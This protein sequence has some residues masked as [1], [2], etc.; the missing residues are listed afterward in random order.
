MTHTRAK[1]Q[2][3]KLAAAPELVCYKCPSCNMLTW[4]KPQLKGKVLCP[5][6]CNGLP[7]YLTKISPETMQAVKEKPEKSSTRPIRRHDTKPHAEE[8]SETSPFTIEF[9]MVQGIGFK[10]MAYREGDGKW[11]GAFDNEELPG[12]VRVLG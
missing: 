8:R 3:N 7:E 1:K 12:T 10:C 5:F 9:F 11:R 2:D 6:C 4:R